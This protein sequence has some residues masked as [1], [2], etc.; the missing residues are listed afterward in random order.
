[1]E[2]TKK[3]VIFVNNPAAINGGA[4][5][6]LKQFIIYVAKKYSDRYKFY[7][8]CTADLKEFECE[9]IKIIDN[10][11]GKKWIDRVYW[12]IIGLK[13]WSKNNNI[14]PDIII[15][16]QNTGIGSFKNVKQIIYLHQSLP[17]YSNVK[18]N[19]F[20]KAERKYWFYRYIYKYVDTSVNF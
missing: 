4:L 17:Y 16:L 11:K 12:D 1:M 6:I 9:N 14:D 8:F 10:I 19:P 18:W 7:I 5:T 15:S 2:S 13:R 3:K 20:A